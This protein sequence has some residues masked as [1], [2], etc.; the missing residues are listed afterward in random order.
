MGNNNFVWTL[1]FETNSNFEGVRKTFT[2]V[3]GD[4]ETARTSLRT[5]LKQL[6]K[7][8]EYFFD[9]EAN[10]RY[11][12]RDIESFFDDND[13]DDYYSEDYK[14]LMAKTPDLVKDLFY[15]NEVSAENMKLIE[16][17]RAETRNA[18]GTVGFAINE[19]EIAWYFNNSGI[20]DAD[21]LRSE[22]ED[23][24]G[25]MQM[26]N[27]THDPGCVYIRTNAFLLDD[28]DLD[29]Y[30]YVRETDSGYAVGAFFHIELQ[31]HE[32]E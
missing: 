13:D 11:L 8:N 21:R 32:V 10:L 14:A 3:F 5:L 15:G 7:E 19:N 6:G 24:I 18:D 1:T 9:G 30:C 29:Y 31:K 16:S 25:Y 27:N 4:F 12:E 20:W 17:Q 23:Y 2:R 28:P 22:G 26:E